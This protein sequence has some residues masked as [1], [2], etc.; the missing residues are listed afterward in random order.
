MKV[1]ERKGKLTII[2]FNELEAYKIASKIEQDGIEFYGSLI[3]SLKDKDVKEKLEI[4]LGEE[5]RHFAFFQGCLSQVGQKIED[6]FEEDDLF[7]YLDYGIFKPY[8]N[9]DQIKEIIN[10]VDKALNLGIIIEDRTI[11][12]YQV[13]NKQVSSDKTKREL[14]AIIEEEKRHKSLLESMLR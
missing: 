1:K 7:R 5:K 13:C 11:K 12:F 4:L 3:G 6:N 9:I 10:D 14:K 8:Q 2:D